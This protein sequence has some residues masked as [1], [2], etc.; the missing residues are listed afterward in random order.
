ME[1]QMMGAMPKEWNDKK[2][3][4]SYETTFLSTGF[5]RYNT[6]KK[7]LS[8]FLR[9]TDGRLTYTESLCEATVF[10]RV[11]ASEFTRVTVYSL[12]PRVWKEEVGMEEVHFFIQH[13][14]QVAST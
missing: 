5:S 4:E 13:P 10:P 9:E 6:T 8:H 12:T 7:T 14:R 1:I 11:Y 2:P 3:V